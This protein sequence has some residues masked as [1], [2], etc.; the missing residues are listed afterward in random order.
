MT[1][2]RAGIEFPTTL[3]AEVVGLEVSELSNR[4]VVL[5]F[6]LVF[7]ITLSPAFSFF[8]AIAPIFMIIVFGVRENIFDENYVF[9]ILDF[10][11]NTK[12][13]SSDIKNRKT[14][15]KIGAAESVPH[16]TKAHPINIVH[17][18]NPFAQRQFRIRVFSPIF[19]QLPFGNNPH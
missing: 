8:P 15:M 16:I 6:L 7:G 12:I 10:C 18:L 19:S 1:L 9:G 5:L 11:D 14:I 17:Y 4:P 2:L 13:V 3:E